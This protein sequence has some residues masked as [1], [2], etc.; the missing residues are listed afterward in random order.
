MAKFSNRTQEHSLDRR[1]LLLTL[2]A[3]G[4]LASGL[5]GLKGLFPTP[6]HNPTF[7]EVKQ[8]LESLNL[9]IGRSSD[10]GGDNII[11]YMSDEHRISFSLR[12]AQEIRG[13]QRL[14]KLANV[15]V[16]GI[17]LGLVSD[18][19]IRYYAENAIELSKKGKIY[20]H[21][22]NDLKLDPRLQ[23]HAVIET[24]EEFLEIN[25]LY[26]MAL[27]REINLIGIEDSKLFKKTEELETLYENLEA[28]KSIMTIINNLHS[29]QKNAAPDV[30]RNI[31]A[32]YLEIVAGL[33]KMENETGELMSKHT[34]LA[35]FVRFNFP[36]ELSEL[37]DLT[38]HQNYLEDLKNSCGPLFVNHMVA[39][40]SAATA[41]NTSHLAKRLNNKLFCL[42]YGRGH[43]DQILEL[44]KKDKLS[45][46]EVL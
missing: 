33:E 27:D 4:T 28:S 17:N 3:G 24:F 15:A 23:K 7:S 11:I 45:F 18:R 6:E 36:E 29:T 31:Q 8:G 20:Q 26:Q 44:F 42:I 16:E 25:P 12:R 32:S 14:F 21:V 13:I 46:L 37:K 1:N 39:Y 22:E 41:L 43:S 9:N 40:R 5:A 19:D 10:Y 38:A 35:P 34:T 2:A 30:Q